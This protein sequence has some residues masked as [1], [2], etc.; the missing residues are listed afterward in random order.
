MSD[1]LNLWYQH[2]PSL[3]GEFETSGENDLFDPRMQAEDWL[4]DRAVKAVERKYLRAKSPSIALF[5]MVSVSGRRCPHRFT[6]RC[7]YLAL[8]NTF[9]SSHDDAWR[10]LV[11]ASALLGSPLARQLL[12]EK[13]RDISRVPENPY[14]MHA[15]AAL[16]YWQPRTQRAIHSIPGIEAEL[17]QM[18]EFV[19]E[20]REKNPESKDDALGKDGGAI[21]C[22][23]KK[24]DENALPRELREQFKGLA[25]KKPLKASMVPLDLMSEHL[26][27]EFPWMEE[28]IDSLFTRMKWR[29]EMGRPWFN[30]P[31]LLLV[32]PPGCGKT[33]FARRLAEL[34]GCGYQFMSVGGSS[35]NRMLAGTARGWASAQ[36]CLPIQAV[37]RSGQAN[38][39]MIVDEVDKAT[40]SRNGRVHDTLLG[41]LEPES[42]RRFFDECLVDH[43]DLS[44]V[45][46]ILTANYLDQVP[47]ALLSRLMVKHVGKPTPQH[48]ESVLESMILDLAKEFGVPRSAFPALEVEAEDS[49]K[50]AFGKGVS[51][52]SLKRALTA[53]IQTTSPI[54]I[55]H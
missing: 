21:L 31:P 8:A 18:R 16:V 29:A 48:F 23:V 49:L 10:S 32:G 12:I 45:N 50:E 15:R 30:I 51:I 25:G 35:D 37:H 42:A 1:D 54:K 46:W 6:R 47:E 44:E 55:L 9:Y 53:A 4:A 41:F 22:V 19:D 26:A 24:V 34:S 13:L 2:V 36:P 20:A 5:E 33:R 7:G 27:Q 28:M 14:V 11:F 39:I 38:P 3:L 43:V 40:G 17:A 52:R